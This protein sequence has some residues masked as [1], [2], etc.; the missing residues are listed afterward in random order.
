VSAYRDPAF[1]ATSGSPEQVQ[2]QVFTQRRIELWGEGLT[3]YDFLRLNKGLDRTGAGF[4]D[5]W[6]Y[7]VPAG[8]D[9]LRLPIPQTEVQGNEAFR[10][11]NNNNPSASR[12][13]AQ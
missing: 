9:L 3:Y 11:A 7:N 2:D 13:V 1:S 5:E 8:S 12:P 10:L 6:D 4:P